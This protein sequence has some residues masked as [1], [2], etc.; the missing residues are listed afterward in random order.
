MLATEAV[1]G[2]SDQWQKTMA[3]GKCSRGTGN[4]N[5]QQLVAGNG[6]GG[7]RCAVLPALVSVVGG[8]GWLQQ[9][10]M[11]TA[12]VDIKGGLWGYQ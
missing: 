8:G 11:L 10:A 5:R 3:S 4:K 6:K 2:R 1:V 9:A 12:A 7:L